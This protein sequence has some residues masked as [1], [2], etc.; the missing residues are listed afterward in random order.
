[1][2]RK[3]YLHCLFILVYH[4]KVDFIHRVFRLTSIIMPFIEYENE[5]LPSRNLPYGFKSRLIELA[6]LND[7]FKVSI[8]CPE[9]KTLR[10]RRRRFYN[11]IYVTDDKRIRN[12]AMK[13]SCENLDFQW[14]RYLADGPFTIDPTW[15]TVLLVDDIVCK[16]RPL[17]VNDTLVL[18]LKLVE[19]YDRLVPLIVGPY[20]RLVLYGHFTWD[21]IKNLIHDN[22]KQVRIMNKIEVYQ[23]DYNEVVKF[24]NSFGRGF[25]NK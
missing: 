14:L 23:R 2:L 9:V 15:Q 11:H 20:S 6:P 3:Q 8:A 13:E 4:H 24:M 1:M 21:Q 16:N 12:I 25:V 5:N 22:V 7:A 17:Y 19:S 18:D 10:Q